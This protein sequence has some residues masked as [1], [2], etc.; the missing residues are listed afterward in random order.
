MLHLTRDGGK[1]W[2]NVTPPGVGDWSKIAMIEASRFDPAVAYV[3]VD[4]HRLDDHK[5]Y[6]YRTRD[7]G[8]TWQPIA[9]GIGE[10]SFVNAI[11]EDTADR[12]ACSLPE[13]SWASTFH[14]TTA[15]TG[16][17]CN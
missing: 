7:Y 1:T 3:A 2:Q 4:R 15:I 17:H 13:R 5:P 12:R 6:I 11:R 9:A 10:H 16:S 14:S 8:K